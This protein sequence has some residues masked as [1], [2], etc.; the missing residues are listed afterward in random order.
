MLRHFKVCYDSSLDYQRICEDVF[1]RE[2]PALAVLEKVHSNAHVHIQGTTTLSDKA[3]DKALDD[4]SESHF[5]R[6]LKS[7]ARPVKQTRGVVDKIGF[8]YMCK[9]ASPTV[10]Y[11]QHIT[12][13]E[14]AEMH[15]A[16]DEHVVEMKNSLKRKLHELDQEL[17]PQALHRVY[18]LEGLAFYAADD[19]MP[20]PNFQKLVLWAMYTSPGASPSL[21]EYVSERI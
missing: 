16:S 3:F 14:I 1:D 17:S 7:G 10:L 9:E 15:H 6:R 20:P 4:W 11:K 5:K 21:K 8:Q 18:R 19:K 12:D 13:D 2:L